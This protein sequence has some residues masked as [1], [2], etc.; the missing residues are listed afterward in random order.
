MMIEW[1]STS[2]CPARYRTGRPASGSISPR[3]PVC[4]RFLA[5]RLPLCLFPRGPVMHAWPHR[6]EEPAAGPVSREV[7]PPCSP[8]RERRRRGEALE[9]RRTR[10]SRRLREPPRLCGSPTHGAAPAS[11]LPALIRPARSSPAP[12]QQRAGRSAAG[13]G[14]RGGVD[15]RRPQGAQDSSQ[16]RTASCSPGMP[17]GTSAGLGGHQGG[18]CTAYLMCTPGGGRSLWVRHGMPG[19][20]RLPGPGPSSC[21]DGPASFLQMCDTRRPGLRR[22]RSASPGEF[23]GGGCT[24]LPSGEFP[25][26]PP[27]GLCSLGR[28]P[29]RP[30]PRSPSPIPGSR[31]L[32]SDARCLPG[33]DASGSA[34]ICRR[35]LQPCRARPHRPARG[36]ISLW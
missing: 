22:Q 17:G 20:L 10:R 21:S 19:G 36:G 24:D 25:G 9:G 7:L 2:I 31:S 35:V 1:P 33:R 5:P 11:W 23:P 6:L 30:C 13:C 3:T 4:G 28:C 32:S 8:A 16:G 14:P 18:A 34:S 15:G 26:I 27:G 29:S 12:G